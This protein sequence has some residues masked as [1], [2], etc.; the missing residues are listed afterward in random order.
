MST[1]D[2]MS[3]PDRR[4]CEAAGRG[5]PEVRHPWA[6]DLPEDETVGTCAITG[7]SLWQVAQCRECGQSERHKSDPG[8][9]GRVR[10]WAEAHVCPEDVA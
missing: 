2:L 6:S 5:F 7:G 10:A 3:E 4:A 9:R 1:W 8:D